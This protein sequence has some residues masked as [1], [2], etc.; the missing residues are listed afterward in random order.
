VS[1]YEGILLI[2]ALLKYPHSLLVKEFSHSEYSIME[3]LTE[4]LIYDFELFC[5]GMGGKRG[6]KPKPVLAKSKAQNNNDDVGESIG[7]DSPEQFTEVS[8]RF[9]QPD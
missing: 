6:H 3:L 7:F 8:K 1:L 2:L 4:R 9:I 5:Y